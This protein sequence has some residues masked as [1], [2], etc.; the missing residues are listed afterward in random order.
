MVEYPPL[1]SLAF[2]FPVGIISA[3]FVLIYMGVFPKNDFISQ[4]QE[5]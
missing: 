5:E 1:L 4:S 2:K 3:G